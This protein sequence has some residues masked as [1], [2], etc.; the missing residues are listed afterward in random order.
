MYYKYNYDIRVKSNND[1]L[2]ITGHPPTRVIRS[3]EIVR[4]NTRYVELSLIL[5]K[6]KTFLQ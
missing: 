1:I 5:L 4:Q 6:E 3:S 2:Y